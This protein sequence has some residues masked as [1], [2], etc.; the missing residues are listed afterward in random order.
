MT[1]WECSLISLI[2]EFT[3]VFHH[4]THFFKPSQIYGFLMRIQRYNT[5]IKYL[6]WNLVEHDLELFW[7]Q[8]VYYIFLRINQ[9][10]RINSTG[11]LFQR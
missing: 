5:I 7:F 3:I 9:L 8:I 11:L 6:V 2:R 1:T 4:N 10:S